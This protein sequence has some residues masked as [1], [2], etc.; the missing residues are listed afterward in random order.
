MEQQLQW[1]LCTWLELSAK[2]ALLHDGMDQL[3]VMPGSYTAGCD[4]RM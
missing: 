3:L 1:H 2:P 4:C